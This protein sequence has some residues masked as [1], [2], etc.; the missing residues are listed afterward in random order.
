MIRGGRPTPAGLLLWLAAAAAAAQT[1]TRLDRLE[2]AIWPEY[3]QPAALV[4]YR[5]WLPADEPLPTTVSLP[6]PSRVASP[7][8][9]AKRAPGTQLLVAPFTLES[10]GDWNRVHLQTDMPEIRLEYYDDLALDQPERSLLFE[11]P[12]GLAIA[13][14]SYEVMQPAGARDL[15]VAPS[16]TPAVVGA[17]GLAYRREE[18]GPVPA[19]GTFFIEIRYTK[20]TPGLTVTALQPTAP[21]AAPSGPA[22]V[23]EPAS[24]AGA[25]LDSVWLVVVP[26]VLAGALAVLWVLLASRRPRAG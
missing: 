3:D 19:A 26:I 14:A 2:V 1:A 4:M 11:W 10:D 8:A 16:S 23:P 13:N 6:M 24:D 17:D 22:P 18:L 12:G 5:G 9:V 15:A 7:S 20:T 25:A 21:P